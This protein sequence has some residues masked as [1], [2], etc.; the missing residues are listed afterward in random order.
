M[1][2]IPCHSGFDQRF[3][4]VENRVEKCEE[5]LWHAAYTPGVPRLLEAVVFDMDGTLFDSMDP[6]TDGFIGVV[7]A[8]GGAEYTPEEIVAAF[9]YGPPGRMLDELLGA[10]STKDHLA[11]YHQRLAEGARDL[12]AYNGVLE[13]ID[14]LRNAGVRIALFTGADRESLELLLGAVG[15]RAGFEVLTGGDEVERAKPAP[16]G[17]ALTCERLGL[18]PAAV[19]YVGDSENDMIAAKAAGALAIGAGWGRLWLDS[20][21]ADVV[22]ARP[23]DLIR[24]VVTW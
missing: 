13:A 16:D 19:A 2:E 24:L 5:W 22:A 11:D 4:H 21:P 15:L 1:P 14:S 9:S 23:E 7:R 3:P 20:H 17:I 12:K 10:P 8:A 18:E 6:V